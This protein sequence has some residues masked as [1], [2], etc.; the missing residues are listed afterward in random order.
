MA[1][2]RKKKND[3]P[4]GLQLTA[5]QKLATFLIV[6]GEDAAAERAVVALGTGGPTLG[7]FTSGGVYSPEF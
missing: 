6:M 5:S 2:A 3:A 7:T 4:K 1:E